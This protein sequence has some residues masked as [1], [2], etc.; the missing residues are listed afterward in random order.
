MAS[1][2]PPRRFSIGTAAIDAYLNAMEQ[3]G[4]MKTLAEPTLTAVSGEQATFK[5]GGEFN[6]VPTKQRGVDDNETARSLTTIEK[7]E[8]GIGLEF[9][10][11]VLS[12]GRISLKIR[13]SV[14][15]PT[16]QA[17]VTLGGDSAAQVPDRRA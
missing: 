8:Y 16:D 2:C 14:S 11:V 10:P 13:T 3:A 7:L 5:V 12:A 9:K 15:E 1:R 6:L 17:S 4:V